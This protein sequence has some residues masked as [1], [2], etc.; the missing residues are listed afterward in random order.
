MVKL[1]DGAEFFQ[2]REDFDRAKRFEDILRLASEGCAQ[3][4]NPFM[5]YP[6]SYCY[7]YQELYNECSKKEEK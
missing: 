2:H 4:V 5:C 6:D 1:D 7:P 3:V